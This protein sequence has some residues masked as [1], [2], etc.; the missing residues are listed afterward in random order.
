MLAV[1][2]PSMRSMKPPWPGIK[3]PAVLQAEMP[4]QCQ[5]R[6]VSPLRHQSYRKAEARKPKRRSGACEERKQKAGDGSCGDAA[7]Q[8]CPGLIRRNFRPE[9]RPSNGPSGYESRDIRHRDGDQYEKRCKKSQRFI[10]PEPSERND[11]QCR[12][13]HACSRQSR[14]TGSKCQGCDRDG[15]DNCG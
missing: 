1:T 9:L 4:L 2:M 13:E 8:S 10:A 12:I 3:S 6:Q 15:T 11:R 5:F 14:A 7:K